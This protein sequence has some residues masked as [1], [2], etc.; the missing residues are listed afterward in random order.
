MDWSQHIAAH[1]PVISEKIMLTA[2]IPVTIDASYVIA[3]LLVAFHASNRFNTPRIVRSQT[4]RVQFWLSGGAY[5]V[6]SIG[7]FMLLAWALRHNS[8]LVRVL[9]M[10]NAAQSAGADISNLDAALVAALMLTAL[11][12]SFPVL[13]DIDAVILHFFHRMGSIPFCAQLWARQMESVFS[14][15]SDATTSM[16][17]FIL[18]A[19]H[20]P[21]ALAHELRTDPKSDQMRFRFARNLAAYAAISKLRGQARFA[22]DYP[23]DVATFEKDMATYFT[24]SVGFLALTDKLSPQELDDVSE[25][26]Q[27]FRT[28][29][30]EAYEEL[31]LMLARM[32][33]YTSSGEGEII[34]RLNRIGFALERATPIAVPF[35]LLAADMIGVAF[36][37]FAGALVSSALLSAPQMP[38]SKAIAI[39]LLVAVNDC[40]A[41]IFALLPKEIWSFADIRSTRERPY[42]SYVLSA[43][44]AFSISLPVSYAFYLYRTHFMLDS[45]P[46][47]Q[48]ASQCKW[49][50]PSSTLAFAISFAC[51]NRYGAEQEPWW[52]RWA[53]GAG[54]AAL[55]G[56]AGYLVVLWLAADRAALY[57]GGPTPSL[58]MPIVLNAGIGAVFGSTIPHWY[59]GVARRVRTVA[60]GQP[61]N[62]AP[63]IAEP[64]GATI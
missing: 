33:L 39:G 16:H 49:L 14:F 2:L 60:V 29:N 58:W 20:L 23:E 4:S 6:S 13:R 35:N 8:S 27:K 15:P 7:V 53:E 45:F 37:F 25:S 42:L 57:A 50:L 31:R 3:L 55:M 44:I 62:T 41:A 52:Q 61:E 9:Q 47:L 34:D 46:V 22:D 24:Q 51:D 5:V 11:L 18:N 40:I 28:L 38:L 36:L 56:F 10:G 54:I 12:P 19:A 64:Q 48:F 43:V 30:L 32:L 1:R 26:V 21:D 63:R 59:R 17:D